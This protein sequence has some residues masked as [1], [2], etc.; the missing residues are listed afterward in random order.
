MTRPRNGRNTALLLQ[1]VASVARSPRTIKGLAEQSGVEY[2]R[3]QIWLSA[4]E[5]AGLVVRKRGERE[6]QKGK[7]PYEFHWRK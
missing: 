4:M 1:A 3:A 2:Q 7:F 5:K 6:Y